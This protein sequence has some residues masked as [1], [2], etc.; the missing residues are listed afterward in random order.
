MTLEQFLAEKGFICTPILDGT[1]QRF[2]R[3]R[4]MSGWFTGKQV[5][6]GSK[7]ITL[8]WF[9]DW[10]ADERHQYKSDGE[11]T[12]AEKQEIE[13]KLLE[14]AAAERAKREDYQREVADACRAKWGNLSDR[15][16]SP[17]FVKKSLPADR[18]YGCKLYAVESGILTAVPA[19]DV[20]GVLWGIQYIHED[21]KKNFTGG[22]RIKGCFH[23]IGA[24]DGRLDCIPPEETLHVV[25]GVATGASVSLAVEGPVACA[26][27]AGNLEAV[28]RA[29]R[30]RR[31][32]L[33][34]VVCGDDD[35]WT[36]RPSGEPWNPGRE[37]AER[38]GRASGAR[39]ALPRFTSL[40]AR[41][42]D[43]NDL[44]ALE[45]LE[46]VRACLAAAME[47]SGGIQPV[48]W[49]ISKRGAPV[50]PTDQQ[51]ADALLE[52][53]GDSLVKHNEDLFAYLGTH[54]RHLDTHAL[55]HVFQQIQA[56]YSGQATAAKI[57]GIFELF[58]Q[59]L[60]ASPVDMFTP[61]PGLA[62]FKNGTL[63][64]VRG[65]DYKY[66]LEFR[67]HAKGDFV[68]FT[69]PLEY[70][71]E[72]KAR[73]GEFEA[74]LD[75]V[76]NGDPDREQKIRATRQM[77]G[78]CLMPLFPRLF[79]LH[80][81]QG[82]GK[83]S[84][85]IPAQRLLHQDNWCSVEPHEFKGFLMETMVGKLVNIVTDINITQP[86]DDANL[87]KIEDRI[88]V[89]IDRKYNT[90]VYAP[91]PATHI[92]GANGVPPT[93]DGSSG[94]HTRRWTFIEVAKYRAT[95]GVYRKDFANWVF[96]LDPQGILNFAV[97]GLEDL[98]SLDGH[99]T[100][101]DSGKEKLADWQRGNDPVALFLDDVARNELDQNT[102]L[103]LDSGAQVRTTV[104]YK[105]YQTWSLET[106]R[107]TPLTR[108]KFYDALRSKGF[109]FKKLDGYDHVSGIGVRESGEAHF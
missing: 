33:H 70:D 40:D 84:L 63:H 5:Q 64:A 85:I 24:Q 36:T 10:A 67:P 11:Y 58:V 108:N 79:L 41:P 105:N 98:I 107:K 74:M 34:L 86:I 100:N 54:W 32:D 90:A 106:G 22:M 26:F 31:P 16:Q 71:P 21:G 23:L 103:Y 109:K 72:R 60:P 4:P 80:G 66:R 50:P 77:Y 101:P 51:V 97:Q 14:V 7:T 6:V 94:A 102:R 46:A 104:L 56:L 8:A 53:Y 39:V 59:K 48:E 91:L 76:F 65:S 3:T 9:G 69:I 55:H 93:L 38:A 17:Y 28:C 96:D 57:K 78:A 92:F 29:I 30:D 42:T 13:S 89:R 99:F 82:S 47:K 44:H 49:G 75:R 95:D 43:F 52:F 35:R 1:F 18:L 87:K 81:P 62:N 15:G 2:D 45:G 19:R 68:T 12:A 27:N 73:N 88:P 20:E 83:S 61:R 25:E 37:N